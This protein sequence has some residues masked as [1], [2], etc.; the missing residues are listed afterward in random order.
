MNLMSHLGLSRTKYYLKD[1]QQFFASQRIDNALMYYFRVMGHLHEKLGVDRGIIVFPIC[2]RVYENTKQIVFP[3]LGKGNLSPLL[4]NTSKIGQQQQHAT[5]LDTTDFRIGLPVSPVLRPKF[6]DA[7]I[8]AMKCIHKCGVAHLDFYLSNFMWKTEMS[9]LRNNSESDNC[10]QDSDENKIIVLKIVDWDSAR[11]CHESLDDV[12]MGR[13]HASQT[14]L[15][16]ADT[17]T[18]SVANLLQRLDISL[19]DVLAKYIDDEELQ[20]DK[21]D[22]LDSRFRE[23]QKLYLAERQSS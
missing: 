3:R 12:T 22:V 11:F 10:K 4:S 7:V 14:R 13:L 17:V 21:K 8:A 9:S 18:S 1:I 2:I 20:S 23:L 15:P 5:V 19:I 16:L 6:L